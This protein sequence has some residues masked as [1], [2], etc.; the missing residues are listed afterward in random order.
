MLVVYLE[1]SIYENICFW[2]DEN[3]P[4]WNKVFSTEITV[5]LNITDEDLD[6]ELENPESALLLYLHANS[7]APQPIALHDDVE[8]IKTDLEGTLPSIIENHPNCI[9][10][11]DIEENVA[12]Q[13]E[14]KKESEDTTLN[15]DPNIPLRFLF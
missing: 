13:D 10:M 9:F 14:K 2:E 7:G 5:C 1:K 6:I 15:V 4:I 12:A 11:L 8:N 3:F